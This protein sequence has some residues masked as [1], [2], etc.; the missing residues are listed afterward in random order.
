VRERAC[1]CLPPGDLRRWAARFGLANAALCFREARPLA[2][3]L[4][5]RYTRRREV[6]LDLPPGR[7]LHLRPAGLIVKVVQHHGL[8]V[9]MRMGDHAV[10][11]RQLMDVILLAASQPAAT[12]VSFQGDVRPLHD[13][14]LLFRH[15]L[16]EDGLAGFP[17]ELDYLRPKP[18]GPR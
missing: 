13:L 1:A 10:D 11:A 7:K 12:N 6:V 17:A 14:T 3:T 5:D 16:G 2:R 9:E 8:P 18:T 4:I 15:R